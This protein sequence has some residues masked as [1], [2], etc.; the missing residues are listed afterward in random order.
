MKRIILLFAYLLILFFPGYIF[1]IP[2]SSDQTT[3]N[4]SMGINSTQQH[5]TENCLSLSDNSMISGVFDTV[6][7]S[8]LTI[9]NGFVLL[10]VS[11]KSFGEVNALDFSLKI[12]A[13]NI[14][15]DTLIF[16]S[17]ALDGATAFMSNEDSTLRFTSFSIQEYQQNSI[18]VTLRFKEIN[19]F[20]PDDFVAVKSYL[21]GELVASQLN[22]QVTGISEYEEQEQLS[23]TPN[24][25][26]GILNIYSGYQQWITLHDV[27]G[28]EV[29]RPI[30][31]HPGYTVVDFGFLLPGIYLLRVDEGTK[32]IVRIII[33]P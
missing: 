7:Y 3:E 5:C 10:N 1:G 24:P 18:I 30:L 14:V 6:F 8:Y 12:N 26:G 31:L 28:R 23:V 13:S 15:Y 19:P 20:D 9:G 21:N 4:F 2:L 16:T 32:H 27:S 22:Y 33:T 11:F 29:V 17:P 25:T